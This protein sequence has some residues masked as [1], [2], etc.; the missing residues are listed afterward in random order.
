MRHLLSDVSSAFKALAAARA[1]TSVAVLTLGIG[2]ALCAT[3]L[4]VLKA[5]R[6]RRDEPESFTIVGVLPQGMWHLSQYTEVL[7]PLRAATYPYMVR[8]RPGGRWPPRASTTDPVL[9]LKDE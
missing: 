5:P 8:L 4:M 3:V 1:F 6:D 7:A 9:V 2:L